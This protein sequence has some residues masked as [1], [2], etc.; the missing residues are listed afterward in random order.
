MNADKFNGISEIIIGRAFV[1][2][3]TLGSGFLEKVYENALVRELYE[4]GLLEHDRAGRN[5]QSA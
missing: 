3:N 1:V 2:S 5:V 4:A